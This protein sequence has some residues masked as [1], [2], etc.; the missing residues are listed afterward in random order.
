MYF[1]FKKNN[2]QTKNPVNRFLQDGESAGTW[3]R[4]TSVV[5]R[6]PTDPVLDAGP[7]QGRLRGRRHVARWKP[8]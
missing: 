2:K 6:D 3:F 8:K 7:A 4:Q 1:T 5:T